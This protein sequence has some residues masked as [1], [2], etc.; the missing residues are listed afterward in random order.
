MS[1]KVY[2]Q[3]VQKYFNPSSDPFNQQ[4]EELRAQIKALAAKVPSLQKSAPRCDVCRVE[5]CE[6]LDAYYGKNPNGKH[7]C[8][9]CRKLK[10]IS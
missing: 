2:E 9:K 5:L 10:G 8:V 1:L 7:H 6:Y 4:Y 3:L